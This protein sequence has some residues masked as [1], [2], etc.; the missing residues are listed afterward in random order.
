MGGESGKTM[1]V[2]T[3]CNPPVLC[4]TYEFT[5]QGV[6]E[7]TRSLSFLH[8]DFFSHGG[9]SWGGIRDERKKT[10][11]FVVLALNDVLGT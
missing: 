8:G 4:A 9:S 2:Q 5:K 10:T 3:K 7:R 6:G 11:G 1:P